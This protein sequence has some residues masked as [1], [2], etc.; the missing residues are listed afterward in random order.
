MFTI[1]TYIES[2]KSR[3]L[4]QKLLFLLFYVSIF[5][6]SLFFWL[7]YT[8]KDFNQFENLFYF[9]TRSSFINE[10]FGVDGSSILLIVLT[11]FLFVCSFILLWDHPL[12]NQKLYQV[13]FLLTSLEL[14]LFLAFSSLNLF[15]FYIFFEITLIPMVFIIAMW[16]SRSRRIKATY[17]FFFYTFIGSLLML[18]SIM[19]LYIE[20]GS[21][22]FFTLSEFASGIA[23]KKQYFLWF[24]LFIGF[25]VKI[26]MF[27][28]HI[29]LPE[30]HVEA[31]T[32]GSVLLAGI[33]LKLGS[34]GFFRFLI[35]IFPYC[36]TLFLPFVYTIALISII[37][38]SLAILR[39]IDFKKIIAY[40]SIGHMNFIVLGLF[41]GVQEGIEG[42]FFLMLSHGFVSSALFILVG[43]LYDRYGTRLI[44]YYGGLVQVMPL[45]SLFFFIFNISN[46][47][48]P[49]TSNFV[50]E[51]LILV[52]VNKQSLVVCF[53]MSIGV[54][55]SAVY[56]MLF[57]ARIIFGNLK[58]N[59]IQTY[60][61][62]TL[63]EL[64]VI[65][66][67]VLLMFILGLYPNIILETIHSSCLYVTNQT[68]IG[69]FLMFY[70]RPTIQQKIIIEDNDYILHYLFNNNVLTSLQKKILFFILY[71]TETF[72]TVL[73]FEPEQLKFFV[74]ECRFIVNLCC[75]P[76][77]EMSGLEEIQK[78]ILRNLMSRLNKHY[79]YFIHQS[80]WINLL[81][82]W[83]DQECK[84]CGIS[85]DIQNIIEKSPYFSERISSVDFPG[86]LAELARAQMQ[87]PKV[88]P[89]P[90][91][92]CEPQVCKI[93]PET[94]Q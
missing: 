74:R 81:E 65:L 91:N 59:Y 52:G 53:L 54:I 43:M 56:S 7:D 77:H 38:S 14:F 61:D 45:F 24:C 58:V 42:A 21:V 66:I 3:L 17:Y 82:A 34:Y 71:S 44:F 15:L 83:E 85:M 64:Y 57:V 41:S 13:F 31:P 75:L 30:A 6:G 47:S 10:Y 79:V 39:Q 36:T 1:K 12:L 18:I 29:W 48:F 70:N 2:F 80:I 84:I 40:S 86:S 5:V 35:P 60:K 16:G 32:V 20:L 73:L 89:L 90:D 37:Y 68:E 63:Q 76:G 88:C 94:K 4:E 72:N 49:G 87:G 51:F 22:D 33:L 93:V 69:T 28:F 78:E 26:P 8:S 92:S 55:F 9:F 27:P 62:L 46:F 23:L 67:F 50:G 19:T 11:A 25:A